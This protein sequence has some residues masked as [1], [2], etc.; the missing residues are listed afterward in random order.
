ML[1]LTLYILERYITYLNNNLK[2]L[3]LSKFLWKKP[4]LNF[5]DV[6]CHYMSNVLKYVTTNCIHTAKTVYR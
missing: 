1:I 2:T 3:W 4:Q 6:I 5:K